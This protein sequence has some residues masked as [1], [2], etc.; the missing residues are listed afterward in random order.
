M[1]GS[2]VIL[3]WRHWLRTPLPNLL[4]L[5]C[6]LRCLAVWWLE[7]ERLLLQVQRQW[8]FRSYAL[9]VFRRRSLVNLFLLYVCRCFTSLSQ[10][11]WLVK[12]VKLYGDFL[13]SWELA[14]AS[15]VPVLER[16]L[17]VFLLFFSRIDDWELVDR[18]S[19]VSFLEYL[20]ERILAPRVL[21]FVRYSWTPLFPMTGGTYVVCLPPLTFRC[22]TFTA[23]TAYNLPVV[24]FKVFVNQ[25]RTVFHHLLLVHFDFTYFCLNF[26][27]KFYTD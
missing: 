10:M 24:I 4:I 18:G 2:T 13:D 19:L 15:D 12:S 25:Y 9:I 23:L 7:A 27:F 14:Y 8:G 5:F 11:N 20:R 26:N 6:L 21:E 1:I 16:W 3:L 17:L 22:R